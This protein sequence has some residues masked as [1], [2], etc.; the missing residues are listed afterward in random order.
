MAMHRTFERALRARLAA[1][2][3]LVLLVACAS[4]ALASD[5]DLIVPGERIGDLPP[6]GTAGDAVR[7]M[8]FDRTFDVPTGSGFQWR[9]AADQTVWMLYVCA[10][11]DTVTAVYV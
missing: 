1:C 10:S 11:A 4:V 6:I 9:N 2:A 5:A 7:A 3:G 8:D